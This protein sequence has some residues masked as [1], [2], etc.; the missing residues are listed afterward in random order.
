MDWWWDRVV[1]VTSVFAAAAAWWAAN[2]AQK[3]ADRVEQ[4]ERERLEREPVLLA[5][6][7]DVMATQAINAAP[8]LKDYIN[9]A[10]AMSHAVDGGYH[11]GTL[12]SCERIIGGLSSLQAEARQF[13]D[14]SKERSDQEL[15]K[16]VTIWTTSLVRTEALL[17]EL[18]AIMASVGAKESLVP[19][20]L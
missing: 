8:S 14:E 15:A 13:L 16:L 1:A 20:N 19:G 11:R 12:E 10:F 5:T 18:R 4:A 9:A 17:S 2:Q 3:G 7:V 6:K